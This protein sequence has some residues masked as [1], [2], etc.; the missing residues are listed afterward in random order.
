MEFI[1]DAGNILVPKSIR[2]II[3][4][5]DTALGN[6]KGAK[7][8]YRYGKLHIIEYDNHYSLHMDRI[9][10]LQDPFGHL[11]V[12][13]PEYLVGAAAAIVVGKQTGTT[14]Y[15]KLKHGGKTD[16]DAAIDALIAG[17]IAGSS[18]GLLAFDI[19][20]SLKKSGK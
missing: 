5:D 19:C 18:A 13:A 4:L 3:G 6:R 8:Q 14:V 10:P 2:P 9:N 12:D 20:N 16:K 11:L 15:N 17:Y 7:K 1:D